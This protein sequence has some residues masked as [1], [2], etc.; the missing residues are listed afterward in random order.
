MI[1]DNIDT[2][3]FVG[4]IDKYDNDV[5]DREVT[6]TI[7]G[8]NPDDTGRNGTI[9][10]HGEGDSPDVLF[11]PYWTSLFCLIRLS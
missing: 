11:L 6:M 5:I 9:V 8:G 7:V 1:D 10:L 2:N 4:A 3:G